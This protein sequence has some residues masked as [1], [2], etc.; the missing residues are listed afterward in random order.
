MYGVVAIA[1]ATNQAWLR[2]LKPTFLTTTAP[3]SGLRGTL[4]L[5]AGEDGEPTSGSLTESGQ[6]GD[7]GVDD[8]A[9]ISRVRSC[10]RA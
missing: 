1:S 8:L 9:R 2:K 7:A 5:P 6:P 10:A 3:R 4:A